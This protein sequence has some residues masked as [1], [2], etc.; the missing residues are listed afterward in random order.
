MIVHRSFIICDI[1]YN[2]VQVMTSQY[3]NHTNLQAGMLAVGFFLSPVVILAQTNKILA[4]MSMFI[5]R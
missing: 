1:K 3:V 4:I 2:R 5:L